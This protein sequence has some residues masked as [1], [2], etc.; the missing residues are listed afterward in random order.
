MGFHLD[1]VSILVTD[2]QASAAFYRDVLGL[3]VLRSSGEPVDGI[4]IGDRSSGDMLHLNQGPL[5]G[6]PPPKSNHFA[7]RT[8]EF[9]TIVERFERT[10]V[11]FYDW[12]GSA[13]TVGTHPLGFRQIYVTDP[14]GYWVEINDVAK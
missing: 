7:F 1:H 10:G 2:V 3:E 4:W 14:D 11:A 13:N 6:L 8:T 12:P 9:Q 5:D